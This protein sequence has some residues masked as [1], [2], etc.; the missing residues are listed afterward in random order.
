MMTNS[1]SEFEKNIGYE[2]KNKRLLAN[3]LTHTSYANEHRMQRELSNERLE[4]VGD[5]VVDFV[6]GKKLFE[7]CPKKL[8]GELSKMRASIV[9][10]N[11]LKDAA[12]KVNLGKYILLGKG[13]ELSGGRNR[14][15]IISDAFEA[16]SA[17][18]YFDSDFTTAQN[19]ILKMLDEN[20][21]NTL[22]GRGN[23]DY[24]TELQEYVQQFKS[25]VR[26]EVINQTGPEHDKSFTVCVFKEDTPV[27]SGQGKSKKEAEQ[28]AAKKALEILKA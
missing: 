14:A 20:I 23:I 7:V 15:S 16:V 28:E 9:C 13:E 24:K 22:K 8:E 26:Y 19:W 11:G 5:A 12:D 25:S 2:F 10:E 1:V 27:C 3:A 6:V 4:F 18:I 17:A 21:E